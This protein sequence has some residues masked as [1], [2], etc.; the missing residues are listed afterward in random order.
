MEGLRKVGFKHYHFL[1]LCFPP[2]ALV[3]CRD[4]WTLKM[5]ALPQTNMY[6]SVLHHSDLCCE[7]LGLIK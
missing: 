5:S 6:L 3:G 1:I 4:L 2:S 7:G